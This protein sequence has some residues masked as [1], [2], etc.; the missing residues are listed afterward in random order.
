MWTVVGPSRGVLKLA[1]KEDTNSGRE[2]LEVDVARIRPL[3][4]ILRQVKHV[5]FMHTFTVISFFIK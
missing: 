1:E 2:E 5:V 4:K 3:M